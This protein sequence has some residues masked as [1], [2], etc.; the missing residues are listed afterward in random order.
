MNCPKCGGPVKV[1]DS[2]D[3]SH[4]EIFRQ[5]ECLNCHRIFYTAEFEVETNEKFLNEWRRYHRKRDK[6]Y[7][8]NSICSNFGYRKT[9]EK[10]WPIP[11]SKIA[12]DVEKTVGVCYLIEGRPKICNC[13]G[14]TSKCEYKKK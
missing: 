8:T 11:G 1:K 4:N 2:V 3:V 12:S 10:E 9:Y 5:R 14:S 6:K 7:E 13:N